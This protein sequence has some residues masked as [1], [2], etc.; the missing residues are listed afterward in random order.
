M[1]IV[2]LVRVC[3]SCAIFRYIWNKS[4]LNFPWNEHKRLN[5]MTKTDKNDNLNNFKLEQGQKGRGCRMI[6]NSDSN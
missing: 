6:V 4:T 1:I 3:Y 2:Q 5:D